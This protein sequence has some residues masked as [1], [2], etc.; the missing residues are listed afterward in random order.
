VKGKWN[1]KHVYH[2]CYKI[3]N[4]DDFVL[5]VETYIKEHIRPLHRSHVITTEQYRWAV[6]KTTNKVMQHHLQARSADFLIS[7]GEKVKRLAEQYL[8][9]YNEQ[10]H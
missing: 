4:C 3:P 10:R 5:Q 2:V 8:A 7:E 9:L 6:A 1:M